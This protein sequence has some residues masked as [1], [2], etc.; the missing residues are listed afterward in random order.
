MNQSRNII[1]ISLLMTILLSFS[2]ADD[3]PFEDN[4]LHFEFYNEKNGLPFKPITVMFQ[5]QTG[6]IWLGS[7]WGLCRYNGYEFDVYSQQKITSITEDGEG[8]L[9][10]GT[11]EGLIQYDITRLIETSHTYGVDE[12]N[13]QQIN[14]IYSFVIG[15][16]GIFWL[17]TQAGLVRYD[18]LKKTHQLYSYKPFFPEDIPYL[19]TNHVH[20]VTQ[21]QSGLLWLG[22]YSGLVGF[23]PST[24]TFE[25][26]PY[27][28]VQ[29]KGKKGYL[30]NV[31]EIICASNNK[32]W[33][34]GS[35]TGL[36]LFDPVTK[37]FK[38]YKT[39]KPNPE[40]EYNQ[41]NVTALL[42]DENGIIWAGGN[43]D[44]YR[45]DPR[46]ELFVI[47]RPQPERNGSLNDDLVYA[48]LQEHSG[49]VWV[50]T[51]NGLNRYDPY[52]HQFRTLLHDPTDE[53]SLTTNQVYSICEG[54]DGSIWIGTL[55]G[56]NR[57]DPQAQSFTHYRHDPNNQ[58]SITD[59][60][61]T[62][63]DADS[64]GNI[65]IGTWTKGLCV[66]DTNT[67]NIK[68]YPFNHR[69]DPKPIS[70]TIGNVTT[71]GFIIRAI[72]VTDD[73]HVWIG[74]EGGG[75]NVLNQDNDT[76]IQYRS[77][78]DS[79]GNPLS[80]SLTLDA[81]R[82]IHQT[83]DHEI[84]IG[85]GGYLFGAR[86]L[87]RK[88]PSTN[89]FQQYLNFP[90][91]QISSHYL[92]INGIDEDQ[93]NRLW[94]ATNYG[95]FQMIERSD[96]YNWYSPQHGF[97]DQEIR[98]VLCTDDGY[99]WCST[100]NSGL[101][102]FHPETKTVINFDERSGIQNLSFWHN[103]G[104][105]SRDGTIYFG[106]EG[107][108]TYL[109]RGELKFN[110]MIQNVQFETIQFDSQ[111]YSIHQLNTDPFISLDY[112]EN[113]L[114]V[115]FSL[116][117]YTQPSNTN[118]QYRLLGISDQW[119]ETVRNVQIAH[120]LP[121][122]YQFE[123]KA[124]NYFGNVSGV[125]SF[126][127]KIHSPFWQ[128]LWFQIAMTL[129]LIFCIYSGV[130]WRISS[131][132]SINQKLETQVQARTSELRIER[133]HIKDIILS[134]PVLIIETAVNG[135]LNVLNP[136]AE[137]LFGVTSRDVLGEKWWK[138]ASNSHDREKLQSLHYQ[139]QNEQSFTTELPITF[140]TGKTRNIVWNCINH[141]NEDGEL[142]NSVIFGNDI[143]EHFEKEILETSNREQQNIGREIHD[144]ICQSLAGVGFMCESLTHRHE[145]M[146]QQD[147]EVIRKMR[148]NI[149]KVTDQSRRIA[150]GL[151]LQELEHG[152]EPAI[153]EL[154]TS[155]QN[156][157][158]IPCHYT[159]SGTVPIH[160]FERATHLYRIVQEALSN[161][162]KYSQAGS[163][164]ISTS[165]HEGLLT[166]TVED[167][168]IGFQPQ[169]QEKRGM[170]LEIMRFRSRMIDAKL[171]ITSKLNVG[172]TVTCTSVV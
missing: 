14:N 119:I 169:E 120:L 57:Y 148:D 5:D 45:F 149:L 23:D 101:S 95:L 140:R 3:I 74:L 99:V 116:L 143:T 12:S 37:L 123:V 92:W 15:K 58:N 84:W 97:F 44:L 53:N 158:S 38:S 2:T 60:T 165:I 46:L 17:G 51:E 103:V 131:I 33:L 132:Q 48:L 153:Q 43:P 137:S 118:Y 112:W 100:A 139:L 35:L 20:Q 72:H 106:G 135:D 65:W 78:H 141:Y 26:Y 105:V 11:P 114:S 151:Y 150:R 125:S 83:D 122:E 155:V 13:Y 49:A 82:S 159:H 90:P 75:V 161:A 113:S 70:P 171:E 29:Y 93:N 42:E 168:G 59:N 63:L 67:E 102:R 138:L 152:L 94:L 147:A 108:V 162:G 50:S 1:L 18:K 127:F 77:E 62:A 22:M 56:L 104:L 87:N 134:S 32:L 55:D 24:E 41:P 115:T 109:P 172:T 16:D 30:S 124:E 8:N 86:G 52:L 146:T 68:R 79:K 156:L 39:K 91:L 69:D 76:F 25:Y 96:N 160:D 163:I 9:W 145:H 107:G 88:I 126:R 81:I 130:R 73:D 142:T 71:S 36:V 34:H 89:N 61:I 164:S 27:Q 117:H 98:S 10:V 111:K 54:V 80:N 154:S 19:L 144:S 157:Y 47:D 129:I 66:L 136:V 166:L 28:I 7:E 6:Y 31:Y 4:A 133:D 128:T 121:G 85:T 40:S 110:P 167:D 21:D 64:R 170:G